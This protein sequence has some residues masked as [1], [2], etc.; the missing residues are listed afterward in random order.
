MKFKFRFASVLK[1]RRHQKRSEEQKLSVL[2]NRR[3]AI[4]EQIEG[5][6]V[7]C[8]EEVIYAKKH[9]VLANQQYYMQKHRQHEDLMQLKHQLN[10]LKHEVKEQRM[11]LSRAVK[12]MRMIEKIRDRDKRVFIDHAEH[13]EQLQQ[14]EIAIQQFNL[15]A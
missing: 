14:N 3:R 10:R 6:R 4:E 2:F 12:R 1:I 7:E 13:I 11:H 5:L 9:S 8:R 15:D